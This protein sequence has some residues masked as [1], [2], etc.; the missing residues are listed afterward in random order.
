MN[1][2]ILILVLAATALLSLIG[3]VLLVLGR[4]RF[5]RKVQ[6][7]GPAIAF[8]VLAYAVFGDIIPEVLEELPAMEMISFIIVGF[9]ACAMLG[10]F[11][12]R[13][14]HH[15]DIHHHGKHAETHGD[16]IK[17]KTQAYTMLAVDSVH[18]V[19]DG[20]VLG[21]SFLAGTATGI[22]TCLAT[23]AHEIPQEVGDFAI[24][25]KAKIKTRKIIIYQAL[26]SLIIVPAGIVAYLV[27]EQ[28]LGGLPTVLSIVAGF[29]L[30]V[31]LGELSCTVQMVRG[32]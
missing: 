27:G 25:Q 15:S 14:H 9:I 28:L 16:E 31:A 30:Y 19:A 10:L 13:Y 5:V 18:A 8:V 21:T 23:I 11:M 32:K 29:L 2:L 1:I 6:K 26:S 17:N 20:I 24:M 3:G 22:P 7:W 12:G 4:G